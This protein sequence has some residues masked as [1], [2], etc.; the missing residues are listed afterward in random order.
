MD[1]LPQPTDKGHSPDGYI[2][3][4][5]VYYPLPYRDP[6]TSFS[7]TI[8]NITLVLTSR[9]GC[10]Y[11]KTGRSV[12]ALLATQALRNDPPSPVVP[13]GRI[14]DTFPKLSL[15]ASGGERGSITA[16]TTQIHR[17]ANSHVDLVA[18]KESSVK[19]VHFNFVR[20][21]ELYWQLDRSQEQEG[22][23]TPTPPARV[24]DPRDSY[25]ELAPDFYAYLLDHAVP[26]LLGPYLSI[27]SPRGQDFFAW[28]VRRLWNL[29]AET[30]VSWE[31]LYEQF[32]PIDR[33]HKPDFRNEVTDYLA[34]ICTNIYPAAKVTIKDEGLLLGPS[35]PLVEPS[36]KKGKDTGYIP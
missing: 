9:I 25:L 8:R 29:A 11:G 19:E 23:A 28:I 16:V 4:V 3:A 32:G 2:P 34:D 31:S 14:S 24:V 1:N 21:D 5:F 27:Q 35:P 13:L 12:L 17:I 15:V 36:E 18:P 7:K 33:R 30:L 6:G 20:Q 26:I 22:G 10:P